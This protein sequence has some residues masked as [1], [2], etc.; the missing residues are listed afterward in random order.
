M[1]AVGSGV[2]GTVSREAA[3]E[4]GVA[5]GI[6]VVHAGGD[7]AATSFGA[8]CMD[9]RDGAYVYVGTSGWVGRTVLSGKTES[10]KRQAAGVFYL[11]HPLGEQF[12]L[13]IASMSAAGACLVWAADILCGGSVKELMELAEG[14]GA[15]ERSA[16]L[17]A[18]WLTGRRCPDPSTDAVAGFSGITSQTCKRDLARA[19]VDGVCFG[20]RSCL[21]LIPSEDDDGPLTLVGGG[22]QSIYFATSLSI[23]LGRDVLLGAHQSV[24]TAGAVLAAIRALGV[25]NSSV[26]KVRG[27]GDQVISPSKEDTQL[28]DKRYQSW[29]SYAV[30]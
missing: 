24:G 25:R 20:L 29:R 14:A 10:A 8:Q 18:P 4:L 26:E 15:G 9:V 21:D 1:P 7:A 22:S 2:V 6:D 5:A 23:A 30:L 28:Y 13:E 3:A 17:F 19:V 16:V 11:R 12:A 27:D